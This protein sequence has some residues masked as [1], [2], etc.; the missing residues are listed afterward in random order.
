M[1]TTLAGEALIMEAIDDLKAELERVETS[2]NAYIGQAQRIK[3]E[4]EELSVS[5]AV[6]HQT[7]DAERAIIR[8][9]QD[10]QNKLIEASK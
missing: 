5:L 7:S 4:I 3:M 1:S 9:A 8:A 6:L 2:A 10:V